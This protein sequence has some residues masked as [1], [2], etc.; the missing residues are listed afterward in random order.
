MIGYEGAT[1]RFMY[2]LTE[3]SGYRYFDIWELDL[4]LP[5]MRTS[6][7]VNHTIIIPLQKW[8]YTQYE[9]NYVNRFS[10]MEESAF[11]FSGYTEAYGS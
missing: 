4:S 6:K 1:L 7:S 5:G 11:F 2:M 3:P 10:S 9:Q 8:G